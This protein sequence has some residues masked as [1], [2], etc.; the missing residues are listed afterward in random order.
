MQAKY[1]CVARGPRN[2][3]L[4]KSCG[5]EFMFEE[6]S[7]NCPQCGQPLTWISTGKSV[8]QILREGLEEERKHNKS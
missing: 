6:G 3:G 1:R 2:N 5:F 7:H 8:A 4:L